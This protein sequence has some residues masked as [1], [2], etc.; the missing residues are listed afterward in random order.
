MTAGFGK[1]IHMTAPDQSDEKLLSAWVRLR[2]EDAFHA[3]VRRHAGLVLGTARRRV[4]SEEAAEEV[5]QNVFTALA[6]K[7]PGLHGGGGLGGWLHRAAVLESAAVNRSEHRRALRMKK[8]A[9]DTEKTAPV[10]SSGLL[11]V[12]DD[13]VNAL[14]EAERRVI[15]MH[16]YESR[17]FADVAER[18][19]ISVSAAKKRG[20]RAMERLTGLLERRGAKAT[21]ALLTALAAAGLTPEA[22]AALP[23][24]VAGRAIAAAKAS[25]AG[26]ALAGLATGVKWGAAAA[27]LLGVAA[28]L[29]IHRPDAMRSRGTTRLE[30]PVVAPKIGS[31][32]AVAGNNPAGEETTLQKLARALRRNATPEGD[33]EVIL[34]AQSLIFSLPL[35]DLPEAQRMLENQPGPAPGQKDEAS[36][37]PALR[38]AKYVESLFARWA[39]LDEAAALEKALAFKGRDMRYAA[40]TGAISRM[41]ARDPLRAVETSMAPPVPEEDRDEHAQMVV[42]NVW[43]QNDPLAAMEQLRTRWPQHDPMVES[44]WMLRDWAAQGDGVCLAWLREHYPAKVEVVLRAQS[45]ELSL[46]NPQAL[47]GLALAQSDGLLRE[48]LLHSAFSS[49]PQRQPAEAARA[50]AALPPEARTESLARAMAPVLAEADPGSASALAKELP[51]GPVRSAFDLAGVSALAADDPRRAATEAMSRDPGPARREAL[52]RIAETWLQQDGP[53]AEAWIKTCDDLADWSNELLETAP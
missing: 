7:A 16:W 37:L 41:A 17:P 14:P 25:T 53:A 48:D 3:L 35:A 19:G 1:A 46:A 20:Q 32:A 52:R 40:W 18:L 6:K 21:P 36:V 11:P 33:D 27:F 28:P 43:F 13:A 31:G 30:S 22:S 24:R 5:T 34:A 45:W 51:E 10:E 29:T 44:S 42:S 47:T 50:F 26:S 49:W 9:E 8:I 2:D 4:A 15:L 39:E 23:V 38:L 12:L